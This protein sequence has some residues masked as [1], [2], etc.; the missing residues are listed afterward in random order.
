[1]ITYQL[2]LCELLLFPNKR[3]ILYRETVNTGTYASAII[4]FFSLV[5]SIIPMSNNRRI[6]SFFNIVKFMK[7]WI[8][9]NMSFIFISFIFRIGRWHFFNPVS[10]Q[11]FSHSRT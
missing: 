11:S 5:Y 10:K 8:F 9:R 6:F 4:I 2:L 1:M 3:V 7:I